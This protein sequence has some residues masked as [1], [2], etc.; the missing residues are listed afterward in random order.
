MKK[1]S[2]LLLN[3]FLTAFTL[4]A[5]CPLSVA[6]SNCSPPTANINLDVNNA[7]AALTN[8]GSIWWNNENGSY[9]FPNDGSTN[10][11]LATSSIFAGGFWI[12][13]VDPAGNLKL[14]AQSYG[15]GSGLTDYFPGPLD[16]VGLTTTNDCNNYDRFW[17]VT[18][19]DI[20]DFISDFQD[21]GMLDDPIP[22]SILAWPG[23]GSTNSMST[24]GFEIPNR[25][26]GMAPFFDNDGNGIYN[27]ENGDYPEIK[28]ATEGVWWVFNDAG[29]IHTQTSGDN[30]QFEI[31]ALAYAYVSQET[32]INNTTFYDF[33][34]I[35]RAVESLDSTFI[36]FW[37]DPDLGCFTDDYVGCDPSRNLAYVYNTD[38]IDGDSGCSCTGGVP[39]YCEE[40]PVMGIKVL[41]G[42]LDIDPQNGPQNLGMSNFG[43]YNNAGLGSSP[44]GTVDPATP[45][46][47]YNYLSGSW[48]DGTRM[49]KG[50]TGYNPGST[51]FTN[52]AF[53]DSPNDPDG[54]SMCS[55]GLP[56]SDRR[57]I[58]SSGPYESLP[59]NIQSVSIAV[60]M[61]EDV[62]HPCPDLTPL[63]D[64]SDIVQDFFD[65]NNI[66]TNTEDLT[67]RQ[68]LKV[69]PNPMEAY[70]TIALEQI[71]QEIK[72][73]K[74]FTVDGRLIR[75]HSNINQQQFQL[76]REGL[77]KGM[78]LYQVQTND[79][80]Y[81]NGKILIQ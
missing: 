20:N 66:M 12:A 81:F 3:T 60:I 41:D 38:A 65:D 70:A 18:E 8:A 23:N 67:I 43:Y 40:I 77:S 10:P 30:L 26:V 37:V 17:R 7:N 25:S 71:G 80:Q 63:F 79:Q 42:V 54:W 45:S 16:D 1:N 64:A 62:T 39:T 59:G 69:F 21:N 50:G 28:G 11:F 36:G 33:K 56:T 46:E 14:A 51:D 68:G 5:L 73:L 58:L 53:P 49:T 19:Q 27:P 32:A 2:L 72:N 48:K 47:I 4:L 57:F 31:Q 55:E 52:Y 78:Y 24:N 34:I 44:P 29:N 61:V 75:E 9:F 74:L 22:T 6:Q 15:L 76:Y 35:N 13:G